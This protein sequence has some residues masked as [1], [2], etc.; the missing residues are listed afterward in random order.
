MDTVLKRQYLQ[1]LCPLHIISASL[2]KINNSVTAP[3]LKA[4]VYWNKDGEPYYASVGTAHNFGLPCAPTFSLRVW[5]SIWKARLALDSPEGKLPW[6]LSMSQTHIF[7]LCSCPKS[8][9][10]ACSP[11][12]SSIINMSY[13]LESKWNTSGT[14]P[15]KIFAAINVRI[16]DNKWHGRLRYG[17][18]VLSCM[19]FQDRRYAVMRFITLTA[20]WPNWAEFNHAARQK[21]PQD[22]NTGRP[23]I[24]K[25]TLIWYWIW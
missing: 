17:P 21:C 12:P 18:T 2:S 10:R 8:R 7:I 25:A 11:N 14:P 20:L 4:E 9:S 1:Y 3:F 23:W 24:Y 6:M 16:N 15:N 13:S 5:W 19:R 22:E